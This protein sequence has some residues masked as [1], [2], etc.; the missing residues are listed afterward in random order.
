MS[1]VWHS[2]LVAHVSTLTHLPNDIEETI[3]TGFT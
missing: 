3:L 2:T 1:R